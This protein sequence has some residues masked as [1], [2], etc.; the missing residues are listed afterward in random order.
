MGETASGR[1]WFVELTN[2][3]VMIF[4]FFRFSNSLFYLR[5]GGFSIWVDLVLLLFKEC[6]AVFFCLC[7]YCSEVGVGSD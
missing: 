7:S 6:N 4:P 2:D 3:S 5:D 1:P